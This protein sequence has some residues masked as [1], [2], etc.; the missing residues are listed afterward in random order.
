[1]D[2]VVITLYLLFH[3][4]ELTMWVIKWVIIFYSVID[5]CRKI[6]FCSFVI[7]YFLF[8]KNL[9]MFIGL[10]LHNEYTTTN[11]LKELSCIKVVIE[12]PG[13]YFNLRVLTNC[14]KT[15]FSYLQWKSSYKIR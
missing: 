11:L 5:S 14:Q 15:I 7:T 13:K 8:T 9:S 4:I 1:M 2:L 3:L 6:S 10:V 12:E